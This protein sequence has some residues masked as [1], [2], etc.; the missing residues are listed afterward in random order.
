[1]A[2]NALLGNSVPQQ[3]SGLPTTAPHTPHTDLDAPSISPI[4]TETRREKRRRE[5]QENKIR[6]SREKKQYNQATPLAEQIG[7]QVPGHAVHRSDCAPEHEHTRSAAGRRRHPLHG[8]S[9]SQWLVI[10]ELKLCAG[11]LSRTTPPH[12]PGDGHAPCTGQPNATFEDAKISAIRKAL[13]RLRAAHRRDDGLEQTCNKSPQRGRQWRPGDTSSDGSQYTLCQGNEPRHRHA[14]VYVS[15]TFDPQYEAHAIPS[16]NPHPFAP[17]Y[18]LSN[19]SS[20]PQPGVRGTAPSQCLA[21]HAEDLYGSFSSVHLNIGGLIENVL[22]R[23]AKPDDHSSEL[24]AGMAPPTPLISGLPGLLIEEELVSIGEHMH[25]SAVIPD[26]ES[27]SVVPRVEVED[28]EVKTKVCES[29]QESLACSNE[30]A[31]KLLQPYDRTWTMQG[32]CPSQVSISS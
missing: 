32:L 4:H 22:P 12:K 3:M 1:M 19:S 8:R 16:D 28:W 14:D 6:K 9:E 23:T 15:D 30:L 21:S 18:N 10:E 24:L 20:C 5:W 13:D 25:P 17:L 27:S 11:C 2:G 31:W 26:C 29:P 7:L